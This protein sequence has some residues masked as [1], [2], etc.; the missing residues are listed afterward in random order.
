[1]QKFPIDAPLADVLRAFKKLGFVIL[2]EGNHISMSRTES[3][4]RRTPLTL[5]N[6]RHIKGST[7]R[8]VLTQ[9]GVSRDDFLQ[10]YNH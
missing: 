10:A 7:L 8:M 1:M 3:D 2:R 5:P 6:H 4:G 9:T